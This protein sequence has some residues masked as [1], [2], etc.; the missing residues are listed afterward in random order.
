MTKGEY[1]REVPLIDREGLPEG[2]WPPREGME[3]PLTDREGYPSGLGDQGQAL[4]LPICTSQNLHI[5]FR[6]GK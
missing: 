3:V 4:Q 2:D 5:L 6:I 1:G